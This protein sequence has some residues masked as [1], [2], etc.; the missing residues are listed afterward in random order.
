MQT[1]EQRRVIL[2]ILLAIIM[3]V[4]WQD[5]RTIHPKNV[6]SQ[7]IMSS[8]NVNDQRGDV[9]TTSV[10][11]VNSDNRISNLPM[12]SVQ[13]DVLDIKIDP[14]GGNVV[15]ASL[16]QY[17]ESDTDKAPV[18]LMNTDTDNTYLAQSALVSG[19]GFN[20]QDLIFNTQATHYVLEQDQKRMVVDMTAT[21]DDGLQITKSYI[22]YPG[23][24]NIDVNYTVKNTSDTPWKGNVQSQL[25]RANNPPKQSGL[26]HITAYFG[27]SYST[28]E[29]A[30]S[31]VSYP[32]MLKT[33]VNTFSQGGWVAMQ[34]HYFLGAWVPDANNKNHF[35][36]KVSDDGLFTIG[37]NGPTTTI[38]PGQE[39]NFNNV[40][41]VG[42][43]LADQLKALSPNLE[44]T[45][46]YGFLW[47]I[48]GIIF[49]LMQKIYFVVGNWGWS[50]ILVTIFI[51]LLFY[52]L[53]A[54]SYRSMAKMRVLQP[55]IKALQER[56]ADD[57]Q[58]LTVATMELYKKEKVSPLKGCFPILIQIPVFIALYWVIV[59]S[60]QLRQAPFIFWIHDLSVKDP[61]FILPVL[62]GLAM[63]FQQ[64]LSPPPP[65]PTQAKIMMLMPVFLTIVF[66]NFPAGLVLYWLVNTLFTVGQ[67]WYI[68]NAIEK[69]QAE[70]KNHHKK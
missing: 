8:Q 45:I 12:V 37:V 48:S 29:D 55:K 51:K 59:E 52:K 20:S 4:L 5:W 36:S 42:P 46:D 64:K 2:L 15:F 3:A 58:K 50:I 21:T 19:Q 23:K 32:K 53:S 17:H 56:Y 25:T 70:F 18:V 68:T 38:N 62:N 39:V 13:T 41:Y 10:A 33:P 60:V 61:F 30:Y 14:K 43:E 26:F 11:T 65:D 31:K 7:T 44:L 9:D 66:M 49:W 47:I 6:E 57:K 67:Q 27:A 24:Y 28:T 40:L 35:Y 16:P 63:F 22:F 1:T 69:K 34:Q 54:S